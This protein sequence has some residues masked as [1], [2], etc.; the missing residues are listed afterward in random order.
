MKY[1]NNALI[2]LLNVYIFFKKQA[3]VRMLECYV[4][5]VFMMLSFRV[6]NCLA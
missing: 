3:Y 1:S 4:C 5:Y 2:N 6:L